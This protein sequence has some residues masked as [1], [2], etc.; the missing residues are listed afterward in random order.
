M[1]FTRTLAARASGKPRVVK[2]PNNERSLEISA[3]GRLLR[4]LYLKEIS[5]PPPEMEAACPRRQVI[6]LHRRPRC[7]INKVPIAISNVSSWKLRDGSRSGCCQGIYLTVFLPHLRIKALH[8][9]LSFCN[10]KTI[11]DRWRAASVLPLFSH[12]VNGWLAS[13]RTCV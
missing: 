11:S 8:M 1:E 12:H 4:V 13:N 7:F 9:R 6:C 2:S 3:R 5:K 10:S